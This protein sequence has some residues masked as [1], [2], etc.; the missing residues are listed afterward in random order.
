V[1]GYY[2]TAVAPT[3]VFRCSSVKACPG[4]T[5]NS[6]GGGLVGTPCDECNPGQTWNGSECK[7]CEVWRQILWVLA[8]LCIFVFLTLAYYLTSSKVTA[9][10]TVLFATTAS[11]GM[12]VMSMQNLGL[13]GMM[14]VE[15]P[16]D[17]KGI[18][19]VC[20]FLLL[21]I[22]SYGFSCIAGQNA[23]VRYLLSALIFPIGV[24][25]L[26]LCWSIARVLPTKWRW[27]GSKV[28][29]TM[30]AFLQVGF[31]TMSATSLAPMMCYKHP[32][33]LRSILKYPGVICGSDEHTSMLV[34]GWLLLSIFV[35]GFVALCTFAVTRVP[36]WSAT[37]KD[38]LVACVRFLVFRFRLDSW[39]FGVP[40][41]CRGPLLSLPVV[42]ATDYPP[43][44]IIVIAVIL[45]GFMVT[46][47][48]SWPWKVPMLNLTDAI[49][50]FCVV[51]LVTTS[52]L[53]LPAIEGPMA[54]FAE[55][56]S[57][58][59]LSGI[60]VALGI[61]VL[62]TGSALIYRSALGGKKEL[63]A[64]N[65]GAVPSSDKLA[66]KVKDLATELEKMEVK[67]LSQALASL[68][69]FDMNKVTTCITLL[70]TEVAP[71]A[72]DAVTYKFNPRINSS[73]FDPTLK[74]GKRSKRSTSSTPSQEGKPSEEEVDNNQP[75]V[76]PEEEERKSSWI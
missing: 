56:V 22:D 73:S 46:Q 37:R 30:G 48:L 10:A 20:Q 2:S 76:A 75:M 61:M 64:F 9:K 4:G 53:H 7:E 70:A 43:V 41:L 55:A 65:L 29:S 74:K 54:Q 13:I 57:T 66:K 51:L 58:T 38:H 49:I 12:L 69:V 27:D 28:V 17:I 8:V 11:F 31:S 14:T 44:Q 24:A 62:M 50:S 23:P 72:E 60:G 6:C 39:W 15:W 21:D 63:R 68:A 1:E 19:S 25:W 35:L 40:L 42:L 36:S 59:M 16:V 3:E 45:A 47:M 52:S 5:P 34:I 18:F 71:P 33:G 67:E 32:N 26:A